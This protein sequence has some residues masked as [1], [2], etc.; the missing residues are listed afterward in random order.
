MFTRLVRLLAVFFLFAAAIQRPETARVVAVGDV[1]GELESFA[2]I[3]QKANLIDE[4]RRWAGGAATLVQTGDLVDRGPKSR[5]VLDF[6]MALQKE[7][8]ARGGSVRIN[9]GNHEVMNIMGDMRYVVAQDYAAFADDRSEQRRREAFRKYSRFQTGKGLTADEPAW[10]KAHPP[11]FV[12][13]REAFSPQ[14]KYGKWLRSL[15]VVNKVGD[16]AFL[17]GGIHPALKPR[18]LDQINS[19]VRNEIQAFDGITRFMVDRNLA[20]PFFTLEEFV[21]AAAAEVHRLKAKAPSELTD[22]DAARLKPLEGLL[23]SGSWLS[24]HD[25]GPLWFRGYDR[26]SDAEGTTQLA[27]L[28]ELLGVTRFVVGHS[29]QG[30]G[31]VKSRFG[32]LAFLIDVGMVRRRTASALEISNGRIRALYMDRQTDLN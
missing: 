1:H 14:G 21:E 6:V 27:Q 10:I 15:P 26:W 20:L 32:G 23:Q 8:S 19:L 30:D 5:A 29:P 25:D 3:L 9:L 4:N 22:E 7:A 17:H 18:S 28:A 2:A 31:L 12:E 11:G 16:T 24:V 13:H